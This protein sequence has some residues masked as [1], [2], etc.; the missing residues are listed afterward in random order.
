[1]S[2]QK[3]VTKKQTVIIKES[4]LVEL[5]E[6]ILIESMEIKEKERITEQNVR[7]AQKTAL[8]ENKIA[9]LTKKLNLLTESK[10]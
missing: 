7:Q 2:K 10:K 1:M 6:N 4:N 9:A 3:L 5:I 8:L